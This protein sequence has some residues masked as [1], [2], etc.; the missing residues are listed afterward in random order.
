MNVASRSIYIYQGSISFSLIFSS[1]LRK[2]NFLS[3]PLWCRH[4]L[5]IYI[6]IRTDDLPPTDFFFP[7]WADQ[8]L[9]ENNDARTF[10]RSLQ[11]PVTFVS[12]QLYT[13]STRYTC[14]RVG[15]C[16]YTYANIYLS[17]IERLCH[18]GGLFSSRMCTACGIRCT[19][20]AF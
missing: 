14:I 2:G 1:K 9:F 20:C 15:I 17:T 10:A 16:T 19:R 18:W 6:F 11:F 5:Y 3:S 8:A 13:R 12:V 4:V 7:S